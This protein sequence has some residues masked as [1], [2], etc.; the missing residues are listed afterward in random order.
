MNKSICNWR[1]FS[2][3]HLFSVA[4]FF[5][6]LSLHRSNSYA[7]LWFSDKCASYTSQHFMAGFFPSH[8]CLENGYTIKWVCFSQTQN[9]VQ[10]SAKQTIF[11]QHWNSP[12]TLWMVWLSIHDN[13]LCFRNF[14]YSLMFIRISRTLFTQRKLFHFVHVLKKTRTIEPTEL[15]TEFF[16]FTLFFYSVES[17]RSFFGRS[18]WRQQI[19]SCSW[20]DLNYIINDTLM[21]IFGMLLIW[22]APKKKETE[23]FRCLTTPF[24][25]L[26][27]EINYRCF[28]FHE[29]FFVLSLRI[30]SKF[31]KYRSYATDNWEW[32]D[33]YQNFSIKWRSFRAILINCGLSNELNW[34]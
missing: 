2:S 28:H 33:I 25:N 22:W 23:T 12:A 21:A 34:V 10:C 7:V 8:E 16:L 4:H 24:T 15:I 11:P 17:S 1:L 14:I 32:S 3:T 9:D 19:V 13:I 30:Y 26:I 27:T 5:F 6:F 20:L 31:Q 29:T 18:V